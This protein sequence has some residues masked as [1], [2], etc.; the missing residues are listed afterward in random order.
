MAPGQLGDLAHAR[1]GV[2]I[3]NE[4]EVRALNAWFQRW[5][6]RIR[7]MDDQGCDCCLDAWD[8]QAPPEALAELPRGMVPQ[9][10]HTAA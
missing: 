7:R 2:T 1:V 3:D 8:V 10:R 6:P 4:R 9:A 5:G